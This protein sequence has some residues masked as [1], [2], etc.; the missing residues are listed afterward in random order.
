METKP[1]T[2]G[3]ECFHC[4]KCETS[5]IGQRYILHD[6]NHYCIEGYDTNFT[7]LCSACSKKI[8]ATAKVSFQQHLLCSML[9]FKSSF[10]KS[11][12]N[13]MFKRAI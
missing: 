1:P 5:L 13:E 3:Q 6:E 10:K 12:C 2:I 11:V 7:N 9:L 4:G 8:T